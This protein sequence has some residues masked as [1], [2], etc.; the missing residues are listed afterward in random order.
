MTMFE[1]KNS[2]FHSKRVNDTVVIEYKKAAFTTLMDIA[3]RDAYMKL[4]ETVDEDPE[5][6][7]LVV[8]ND[9]DFNEEEGMQALAGL[10]RDERL[11]ASGKR[12]SSYLKEK[13]ITTFRNAF[14][15]WPKLQRDL[16]FENG[17]V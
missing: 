10:W 13:A 3:V 11:D 8:V 7:G 16:I 5:I 4:I 17:R 9:T 2:A 14:G 12:S 6:K 1:V 15:Q